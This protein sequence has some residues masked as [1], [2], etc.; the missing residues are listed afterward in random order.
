MGIAYNA[1]PNL[2]G[3]VFAI[4][5]ANPKCY[6]S[7]AVSGSTVTNIAYN[8]SAGFS[9]G[10]ATLNNVPLGYYSTGSPYFEFGAGENLSGN[11]YVPTYIQSNVMESFGASS[12]WKFLRD[13]SSYTIETWIDVSRVDYYT[14]DDSYSYTS[15]GSAIFDSALY[16]SSGTGGPGFHYGFENVYHAGNQRWELRLIAFIDDDSNDDDNRLYF[17][18]NLLHY[19]YNNGSTAISGSQLDDAYFMNKMAQF[20]Y[21]FEPDDN[22]EYWTGKHYINAELKGTSTVG[23]NPTFTTATNSTSSHKPQIGRALTYRKNQSQ[24]NTEYDAKRLRGNLAQFRV[25]KDVALTQ[26]QIEE[27]FQVFRGRYGI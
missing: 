2:D 7:A 12:Y 21:T 15:A 13:G 26:D 24:P 25:Y 22:G 16:L 27:N 11:S 4:D 23:P 17:R 5:A 8:P 1:K 9:L 20:V 6:E 14:Y 18:S 3:L 10:N 19:R